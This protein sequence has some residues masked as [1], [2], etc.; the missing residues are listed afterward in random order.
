M[1]WRRGRIFLLGDAAHLA[2]PFI[3]QG[4]GAGLRDAANLTWKLAGVLRAQLPDI[5]LDTYE[6]ERK[7]HTRRLIR[8][9]KLTG[10]TMTEGGEL[11]NLL[12]RLSAPHLHR[13][14][15]FST[16]T[17]SGESPPLRRSALIRRGRFG[18]GLGGRLVPNAWLAG[19]RRVDELFG[20]RYAIVTT[21]TPSPA[22]RAAV[23]DRGGVLE[24]VAPGTDL[25]RWL[26]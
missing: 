1:R 22:D 13:I 16:L 20:G 9:A 7:P 5:A 4:L 8:L 14:P 26:R 25:Y 19:G 3:G 6:R 12:R 21:A 15:G 18:L 23:N 10:T 11:G 2:L 24:T 17:T